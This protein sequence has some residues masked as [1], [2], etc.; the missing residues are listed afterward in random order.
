MSDLAARARSSWDAKA[1]EWHQQVGSSGDKNRRFNSDPVLW[2]LLGD[3]KGLRVLDAGCGTGYL[4]IKLAQRGASVVSI[5]HSSGMIEVARRNAAQA[6]V[7]LEFHIASCSKMTPVMGESVDRIVSNYVLMD[8]P[9]MRGAIEEFHRVL[10][11][12]G[13]AAV[14]FS[15]P[16]FSPPD[17][18][19]QRQ[20]DG[21]IVCRWSSSYFEECEYEESWG[22]FSTPFISYHRPLSAYWRTF[23][24]AGFSIE[25][26]DEPVVSW[27]PP[28]ALDEREARRMRL[29]PW[30]VAFLLQKEK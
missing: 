13:R 9:D 15:H 30:S 27:P 22:H 16:S 26:F 11:P 14:V 2:R 28:P 8:L 17:R 7:P 29:V 19:C 12:G 3:V 5:D 23:R 1:E 18:G 20:P 4:S 24:K 10:R 6:R 25:E 21:S